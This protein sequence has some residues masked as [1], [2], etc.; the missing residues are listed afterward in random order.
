MPARRNLDCKP[1]HKSA[2]PPNSVDAVRRDAQFNLIISYV[3]A[4]NNIAPDYV[5][6]PSR[7]S[8]HLSKARHIV[9]YL[10]H[11]GFGMSYTHIGQMTR[12]DR[13]SVAHGVTCSEDR[14]DAPQFDRAMHFAELALVELFATTWSASNDSGE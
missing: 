6:G 2:P 9:Y 3:R 11:V 1:N 7:G 8:Q 5:L 4:A 12:R 10:S 14:R 13:T